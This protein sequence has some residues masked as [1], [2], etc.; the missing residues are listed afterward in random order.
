[1]VNIFDAKQLGAPEDEIPS[2]YYMGNS[3]TLERDCRLQ[4][5]HRE[6]TAAI[7]HFCS[8]IESQKRLDACDEFKEHLRH[9]RHQYTN[10]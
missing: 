6:P 2:N 9:V 7:A 10:L 3:R 8:N 5:V 4:K 1:M